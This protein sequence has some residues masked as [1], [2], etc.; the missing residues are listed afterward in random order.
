MHTNGLLYLDAEGIAGVLVHALGRALAFRSLEQA[1][2][3]IV[4]RDGDSVWL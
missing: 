2:R 1:C 3:S 4:E